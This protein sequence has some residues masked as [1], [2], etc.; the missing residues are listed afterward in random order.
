MERIMKKDD[1]VEEL[2]SRTSFYKKNLREIVNALEDIVIEHFETAEFDADSEF[3][4]APGIVI[5]GKRKPAGE[6][7]DPRT[8]EIIISP[9]K[10]IP[11]A[12]FKQSV[13][14]KLYKKPKGYKKKKAKKG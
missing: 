12:V 4:L 3:H 1:L 13:R 11:S 7:K 9:E 10:V 8:G 6:A 2:A 5:V 14:Q